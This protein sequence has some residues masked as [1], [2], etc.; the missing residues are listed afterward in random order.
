MNA[1]RSVADIEDNQL[2]IFYLKNI[3]QGCVV[4]R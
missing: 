3:S 1:I 2:V 4:K